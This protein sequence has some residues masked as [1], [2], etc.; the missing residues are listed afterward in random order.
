MKEALLTSITNQLGNLHEEQL[1]EV[2]NKVHL[3]QES[4]IQR[5][6]DPRDNALKQIKTALRKGYSF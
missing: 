2:L 5:V 4:A 1:L 3:V 6:Q